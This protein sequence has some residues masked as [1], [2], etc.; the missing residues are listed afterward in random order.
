MGS[1]SSPEACKQTKSSFRLIIDSNFDKEQDRQKQKQ[2]QKTWYLLEM[3]N[4]PLS[5]VSPQEVR[6][7][8]NA[9]NVSL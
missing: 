5:G 7:P 2:K 8:A 1:Q 9:P 6:F 3:S 4:S